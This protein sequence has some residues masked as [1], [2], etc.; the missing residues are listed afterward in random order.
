[1]LSCSALVRD[2]GDA[3]R[4]RVLHGIDLTVRERELVSLTGAS[5]S[6]KSTLLYLLGALDRPTAGTVQLDGVDIAQLTDDDRAQLRL[7]KLGFVFQF[8][9]L[10]PEFTVL[11]NVTLPMLRRGQRTPAEA[12]E[13]AFSVLRGMGLSGLT[14]RYP[15]QLSGGQQQRV[16]IARALSNDPRVILADEPTGNLDSRHAEVVMSSLEELVEREQVTVVMVTHERVFAA[17][18][19]R[20]I[21]LQDGRVVQDIDQSR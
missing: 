15:H 19:S 10:L 20:Q 3:Q 21:V 18:A 17:R 6:G 5:G 8:H 12:T 9:F 7:C 2:F 1:V 11:E 13:R 16:S 14:E 4:V